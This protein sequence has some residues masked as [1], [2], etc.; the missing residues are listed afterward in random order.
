MQEIP[1][2]VQTPSADAKISGV[3]AGKASLV[4]AGPGDPGLITVR[5]AQLLGQADVVLY[6]ALANRQ[7]LLLA[8][9]AQWISVGKHGSGDLWTQVEINHKLLELTKSGKHVVRLK[10]GDPAVFARTAE[11]LQVLSENGIPFEVVPGITAALAA[12]SY[13]GIPITHRDYASA[14][15]LITGQQQDDQP[16]RIDWDALVRFPGTLVF[17]MGVTSAAQW[18]ANLLKA[19]MRPDMPTAIVRRCSWSDQVVIRCQLR[20]VADHLTPATKLRPPVVVIVGEVAKLGQDMDWFSTKPL[21]GVGVLVTRPKAQAAGL[22]SRLTELGADVYWQAAVEIREPDSFEALDSAIDQLASGKFT[23]ITFSS[24]NGVDALVRRVWQLG[25]DN[26]VFSPCKLA[27]VG[28]KTA[29]QLAAHGLRADVVPHNFSAAGLVEILGDSVRGQRWLSILA[30]TSQPTL[31][32]GLRA[33]GAEVHSVLAYISQPLAQLDETIVEALK[34]GRITWVTIT[35]PL[36]AR[37][38][39][40]HCG[41]YLAQLKPLSLSR[42]ISEELQRL[43]WPAAAQSAEATDESLVETLLHAEDKELAK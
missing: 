27:V 28:A 43:G 32:D 13:A 18:T 23:G 29:D 22:V 33:S 34:K 41:S 40:A 12:A 39:F 8:P 36:I 21:R 6:D 2:C 25:L 1:L 16:Q 35:S 26:R 37:T 11:E 30:D 20:D 9:Q 24:A 7:L 17:Y 42:A 4:G 31:I 5:G 14:V 38:M 10:G 15:A 19:G 3:K